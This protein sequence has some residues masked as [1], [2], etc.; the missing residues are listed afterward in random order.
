V[1]GGLGWLTF[2]WLPL[3][4]RHA[5]FITLVALIGAAAKTGSILILGLNEERWLAEER[6]TAASIWA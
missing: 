6:A 3:G 2:L 4:L 1:I 5:V